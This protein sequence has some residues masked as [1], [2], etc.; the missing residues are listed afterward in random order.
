MNYVFSK[1]TANIPEALDISNDFPSIDDAK[2]AI[3]PRMT[4]DLKKLEEC[5]EILKELIADETAGARAAE[6]AAAGSDEK[7]PTE[8]SP[9][10][11]TAVG[12]SKAKVNLEKYLSE[13]RK[14]FEKAKK[15]LE[16]AQKEYIQLCTYFGETYPPMEPELFF[17]EL[18]A[19]C[20]ATQAYLASNAGNKRRKAVTS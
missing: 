20:K 4:A 3:L 17:G 5:V 2:N 16:Q 14:L 15:L 6:A 18:S 10:A 12:S 1:I 11:T 13:Q 7:T 8:I 9:A 19:L